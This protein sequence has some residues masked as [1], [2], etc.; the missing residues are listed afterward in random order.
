MRNPFFH[1]YTLVPFDQQ[2]S[3]LAW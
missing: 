3:N 1:T 2:Q